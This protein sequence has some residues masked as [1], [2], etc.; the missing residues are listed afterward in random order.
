MKAVYFRTCV[1]YRDFTLTR[2]MLPRFDSQ[3][4]VSV[5][6]LKPYN[7]PP[8]P[9]CMMQVLTAWSQTLIRPDSLGTQIVVN[10]DRLSPHP[11][12]PYQGRFEVPYKHRLCYIQLK[13]LIY[14]L[15]NPP[16]NKSY[17]YSKMI[18]N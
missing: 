7:S 8:N 5:M 9:V 1:L 14:Y 16:E 3:N 13:V 12:G 15:I 11:H 6:N 17:K 18:K 10:W 2:N 4:V